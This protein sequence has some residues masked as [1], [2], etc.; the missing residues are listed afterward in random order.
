MLHPLPS[1]IMETLPTWYDK[2]HPNFALIAVKILQ[3]QPRPCLVT[4][5]FVR[6]MLT[7]DLL[8]LAVAYLLVLRTYS[9]MVQ[10]N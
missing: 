5:S 3:G 7:R 2:Q 8:L 10:R 4:K 1:K 6:R 9:L